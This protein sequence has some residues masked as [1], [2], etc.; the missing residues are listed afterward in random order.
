[1]RVVIVEDSGLVRGLL[2]EVLTRHGVEVVGEAESRDEAITVVGATQPDV[3]V[4]DIRLP[5]GFADDGLQAARII[6]SR[7]PQ[8]GLLV[9]SHYLESVYAERLL[10]EV[11]GRVGYLVKDRVQDDE[12]LLDAI[13]RVAAG[14]V[15]IDP[16]LVRQVMQRKRR[17]N[18]LEE[19][20]DTERAALALMAEGYSNAAI[21]ER[22]FCSVKTVEKRIGAVSDKL[23]LLGQGRDRGEVN[24]RVLA[25]LTYLRHAD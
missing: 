2:V 13:R 22:L 8:V 3:A 20:T 5:P 6:R 25:T 23:G 17:H 10:A 4:L 14:D 7:W 1:V 12:S 19:L 24:M 15:V 11:S 18:P 9:L 21:A 16:E